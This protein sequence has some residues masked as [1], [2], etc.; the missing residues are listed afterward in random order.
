MVVYQ[1]LQFAKSEYRH[2]KLHTGNSDVDSMK[3]VLYRRYFR[4]LSEDSRLPD[5]LLV[6]GGITQ[7]NAAKEILSSLA[8]EI[9]LFGLVK[10]DKHNTSGLMNKE[11][12]IIEV[13]R[14]SDAFFLLTNL[15]D[16][17]HRFAISYHR[18]LRSK[19]QT[20]SILDEVEGI[21]PKRKKQLINHFRSFKKIK[22][23]S[24]EELAEILPNDVAKRLFEVL[25]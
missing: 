7:I 12:Q 1:N 5:L 18:K 3:E 17:V 15:Q 13:D 21:G 20:Q 19:A 24:V 16:E 9:P 14:S 23:A 22:E 25:H 11:G 6:D 10:D 2:Y 4:A 8:L